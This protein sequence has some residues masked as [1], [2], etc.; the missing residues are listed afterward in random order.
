MPTPA[1]SERPYKGIVTRDSRDSVWTLW[2]S[3]RHWRF[4]RKEPDFVWLEDFRRPDIQHRTE[5]Q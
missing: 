3:W 5:R 1:T 2:Q 4:G